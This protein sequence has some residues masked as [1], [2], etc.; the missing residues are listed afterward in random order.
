MQKLRWQ[1]LSAPVRDF[2][3]KAEG[4]GFIAVE[5]DQGRLRYGIGTM[6]RPSPERQQAAWR[7][8]E[9]MQAIVGEA[10]RRQGVTES[11]VDSL[12]SR[13]D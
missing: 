2:L 7:A 4:E 13:N 12:L 11:D 9:G 6:I 10:M 1:D 8:I 5:D 3:A